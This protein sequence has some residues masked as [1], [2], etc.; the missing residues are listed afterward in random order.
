[1]TTHEHE[2]EP[3]VLDDPLVPLILRCLGHFEQTGLPGQRAFAAD[4]VD[5]AVSRGRDQ[6][7]TRIRRRSIPWP[8]FGGDREGV[9]NGLLGEIEIAEKADQMSEDTSPLLT[10]DTLDQR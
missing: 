8:A 9:L 10:E 2:L 4:V 7:R 5:R 6:P 3:L 1:V